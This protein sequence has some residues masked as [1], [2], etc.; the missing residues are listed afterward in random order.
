MGGMLPLPSLT[1]TCNCRKLSHPT[2]CRLIDD[3]HAN[4]PV[5]VLYYVSTYRNRRHQSVLVLQT[6]I[7]CDGTDN[8]LRLTSCTAA[9]ELHCR[10][11][12]RGEGLEWNV[13]TLIHRY[14][15]TLVGE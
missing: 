13:N 1:D 9:H 12:T 10:A 7:E 8:Q 5:A 3:L 6:E 11:G 4:V 15:H 2:F 14:S